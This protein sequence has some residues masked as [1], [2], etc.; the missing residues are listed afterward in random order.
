MSDLDKDI[1]RAGGSS[2]LVL[3][4]WSEMTKIT[5]NYVRKKIVEVI[6]IN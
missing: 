2:Q 5:H 6:L 4:K 1:W 3:E